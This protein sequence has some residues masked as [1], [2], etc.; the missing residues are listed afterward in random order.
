MATCSEAGGF[1]FIFFLSVT[2]YYGFLLKTKN[3]Q[4]PVSSH[5]GRLLKW[6]KQ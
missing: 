4:Q 1:A 2:G 3:G 5:S 6:N